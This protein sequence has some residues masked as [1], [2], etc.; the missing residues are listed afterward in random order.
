MSIEPAMSRRPSWSPM[1]KD[2]VPHSRHRSSSRSHRNSASAGLP[3]ETIRSLSA[4]ACLPTFI[5][6][7][8]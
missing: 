2:S 5:N 4:S 6:G 8:A 7:R 1:A 3:W